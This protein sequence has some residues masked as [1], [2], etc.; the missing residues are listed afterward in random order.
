[1]AV[2]ID[3]AWLEAA[4]Y[5]EASELEWIHHWDDFIGGL[6]CTFQVHHGKRKLGDFANLIRTC[7]ST[8]SSSLSFPS[9]SKPAVTWSG[10]EYNIGSLF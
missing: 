4:V 1:M 10:T 8:A 9:L 7:F 3:A 5:A 2:V 6:H